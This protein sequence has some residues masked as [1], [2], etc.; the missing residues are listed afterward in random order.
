MSGDK[1]LRSKILTLEME[2][3]R[4]K[5]STANVSENELIKSFDKSSGFGNINRSGE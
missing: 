5:I 3:L 4:S 1:S 2:S